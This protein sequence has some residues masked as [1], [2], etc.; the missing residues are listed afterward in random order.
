MYY[1]YVLL[2]S[3]YFPNSI[4]PCLTKILYYTQTL[5][6]LAIGMLFHVPEI[7]L[8]TFRSLRI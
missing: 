2:C 8:L 6:L 3:H 1:V 5:I 7:R 4:P